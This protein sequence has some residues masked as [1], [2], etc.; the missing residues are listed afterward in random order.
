MLNLTGGSWSRAYDLSRSEFGGLGE[1]ERAEE[2]KGG[3]M[4]EVEVMDG[5][6]G[7]GERGGSSHSG[8]IGRSG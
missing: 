6:V 1:G 2:R 7:G 8:D 3:R 5:G 4:K